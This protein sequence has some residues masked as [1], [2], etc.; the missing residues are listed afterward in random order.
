METKSFFRAKKLAFYFLFTMALLGAASPT[1]SAADPAI[2]DQRQETNSFP[3]VAN[4]TTPRYQSFTPA[5]SGLLT[6]IEIGTNASPGSGELY[7]SVYRE[8]DLSTPLATGTLPESAASAGGWIFVPFDSP[9][10]LTREIRYRYIVSTSKP[11]PDG[12]LLRITNT[13]PYPRGE[14]VHSNSGMDFA[15]RT[16]MVPDYSTSPLESKVSSDSASLVADGT[17][18]A[19]ITV[20]LADAQG[21]DRTAG[22]EDV[23]VTATAGEIGEVT[24]HGDGTY[25]AVLTSS[26]TAGTARI[27]ASIDGRAIVRT[28]DVQF[29]AGA[30]SALT[31]AIEA[32]SVSLTAN[33]T[34]ATTLTVRL[35][36]AYGN[37]LTTGGE[38]VELRLSGGGTLGTVTDRGNGTYTATLTAPTAAGAATIS[39][40]LGGTE[41]AHSIS[42]AYVPGPASA[43]TSAVEVSDAS[44]P[45]DGNSTATITIR[46]KDAN[47]NPLTSGGAHVF[48]IATGA[49]IG[50]VTDHQD[51]TYT[52]VLTAS[53]LAGSSTITAYLNGYPIAQ[54][55]SVAFV[56]GPVSPTVSM[57]F[58]A[59]SELTADGTSQTTVTVYLM[60]ARGN[61]V[62]AG[63]AELELSATDG[64]LSALTANADRSYTATLTSSTRA[65][66]VTVSAKIGGV[67][68]AMNASL[69][70]LPGP[71]S[72]A[73]SSIEA[74]PDVLPADGTSRTTIE[75]TLRDAFGNRAANA[76]HTVILSTTNGTL[77]G[78]TA[79]GD[80][81]YTATLTAPATAGTAVVGATL[82]GAPLASAALVRFVSGDADLQAIYLD[83]VPLAGFNRAEENYTVIFPYARESVSVTA[84]VYDAGASAAVLGD[85]PLAVGPNVV[86]IVVTAQDGATTKTYTVTVNR[87][88]PVASNH[89]D[90]SAILMDGEPIPG[91][92]PAH[93]DYA[94]HVPN[95][96]SAV[97]VTG[98]VYD[99]RATVTVTGSGAL[100]VGDNR[101][102]LTVTA[103]DG[104]TTK[105]YA[106]LV[107]RDS[108][109]S[110][111]TSPPSGPQPSGNADLKQLLLDGLDLEP[112]FS[113]DR[114][115][116]VVRAEDRESIVLKLSASDG[117]ATYKVNGQAVRPGDGA[118]EGITIPLRPGEN[119]VAI[120]VT[121]PNGSKKVYALR[122]V[123]DEPLVPVEPS[124]PAAC[125]AGAGAF[126]DTQ[127]HWAGERIREG[128]CA[129]WL[130]GIGGDAFKPDAKVS[131]A[132]FAVM[133]ARALGL[134]APASGLRFADAADIPDWAADAVAQAAQ[135]GL[136]RGYADGTFG[137]DRPVSRAEIAAMAMRAVS[138][139][140]A[141]GAAPE[142]ADVADI[143]RWALGPIA[144]AQ[145]LGLLLGRSGNRFAP[146]EP[147]TRAEAAVLLLRLK[148]QL[149]QA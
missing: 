109:P 149:H 49:F 18:Q 125:P 85:G 146:N 80:G 73:A 22:G 51:G 115:E 68:L 134:A 67:F 127:G 83:G 19:T 136:V 2:V 24:D 86:T 81:T 33:G 94:I 117:G 141:E 79:V 66:P 7:L 148:G 114:T 133:L 64:E 78:F 145:R 62:T 131:R 4:A 40:T 88:A 135:A 6:G 9:P 58:A 96:K 140:A 70:F 55:A 130:K 54:Q 132:E 99:P 30:A 29:V 32:G 37:P 42:I 35:K 76:A 82:D 74:S 27:A 75:V 103:E 147:M 38:S 124:G 93:T 121:A 122:I 15:F 77:D 90:L 45:A 25:S 137:A 128:V 126:A 102:E 105:T 107:V 91:F 72:A 16:Y 61:I 34:S 14:A 3:A 31:S 13:N 71:A 28:T 53:T 17:S 43:A 21:T 36:D 20:R 142:Y 5:I 48:A 1:A 87:A 65:G 84:A 108:A 143:P 39:G 60:D 26:T 104:T 89:A 11:S 46:L 138:G 12:V 120:E 110:T 100:I 57:I 23:S 98:A 116:Y 92:L 113:P 139:Q 47:G 52:A 123:R 41:L 112:A 106:L 63:D 44:L 59:G 95:S 118:G 97:A 56:P 101:F 129:G 10:Y 50:S 69:E 111:P 119:R 144:E 8:N